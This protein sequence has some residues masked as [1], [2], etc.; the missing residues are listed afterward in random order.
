MFFN[1]FRFIP[2]ISLAVCMVDQYHLPTHV[3]SYAVIYI[4]WGGGY[5][6]IKNME[7]QLFCFV[8]LCFSSVFSL[9]VFSS[10][11]VG[12]AIYFDWTNIFIFIY[13]DWLCYMW[14]VSSN[15]YFSHLFIY[16]GLINNLS[17]VLSSIMRILICVRYVSHHSSMWAIRCVG[18]FIQMKSFDIFSSLKETERKK[19]IC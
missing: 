17:M 9:A 1:L 3:H 7:M 10:I 16:L 5:L 15:T 2:V 19:R 13:Y 18:R 4:R 11:F 6:S 14:L 8:L 12:S